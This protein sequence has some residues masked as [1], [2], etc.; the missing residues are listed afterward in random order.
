MREDYCII[1]EKSDCH[2]YLR[3]I[4]SAVLREV[5]VPLTTTKCHMLSPLKEVF[6]LSRIRPFPSRAVPLSL[7]APAVSSWRGTIADKVALH[8][9][10]G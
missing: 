6:P 1:I 7:R 3:K 2:I 10:A 8:A 9:A 5:I 4:D